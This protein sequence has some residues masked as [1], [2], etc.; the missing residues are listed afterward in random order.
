MTPGAGAWARPGRAGKRPWVVMRPQLVMAHC[1]DGKGERKGQPRPDV[2]GGMADAGLAIV[3]GAVG[4]IMSSCLNGIPGPDRTE[5]V[6]PI[7][8]TASV[9]DLGD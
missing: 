8:F 4:E 9:R 5:A 2:M 1:P 7:T 6:L 3:F